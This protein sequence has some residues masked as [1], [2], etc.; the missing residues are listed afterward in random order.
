MEIKDI[1]L[2]GLLIGV[3]VFIALWQKSK[4]AAESTAQTQVTAEEAQAEIPIEKIPY[5]RKNLMTKNEWAFYKQLKPVADEMNLSILCKT[6][7]ADLI[8][9]EKGLNKSEWQAAFNKINK[10][11][12]DFILCNP[13]NLFPL[14]LIELDDNSHD[15]EKVRQR[16]DF[17]EK[18]I[19]KTGYKL[20]RI[21]GAGNLK[22]K[23]MNI[24]DTN[25]PKGEMK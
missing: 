2:F 17:I 24:L 20:L 12:I 25:C 21:K 4:K 6:R 9:I 18:I 15:T 22:E 16:D 23:I 13:E 19:E 11:H 14:L 5:T 3:A 10:K 7:L 8:D 1:L